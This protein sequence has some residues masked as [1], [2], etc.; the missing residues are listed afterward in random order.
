MFKMVKS[1]YSWKK[2]L[3]C[4]N[5]GLDDLRGLQK[6]DMCSPTNE[7]IKI[8]GIDCEINMYSIQWYRLNISEN[9][10][11]HLAMNIFQRVVGPHESRIDL[12]SRRFVR[13]IGILGGAVKHDFLEIL[14]PFLK[15]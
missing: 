14:K 13:R 8:F 10:F 9:I 3:I 4:E 5:Q 7:G 2:L 12:Y 15:R 6:H 1:T 11:D